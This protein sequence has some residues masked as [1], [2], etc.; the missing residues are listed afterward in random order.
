[1]SWKREQRRQR[2]R[3]ATGVGHEQPVWR[4][5]HHPHV[6]LA[7]QEHAPRDVAAHTA[8]S[9]RGFTVTLH[10]NYPAHTAETHWT[11]EARGDSCC[12][13]IW[14]KARRVVQRQHRPTRAPRRIARQDDTHEKRPIGGC[15]TGTVADAATRLD[16]PQ[17]SCE[18]PPRRGW[19]TLTPCGRVAGRARS[20]HDR[21][22]QLRRRTL[23]RSHASS[24]PATAA[25]C[26]CGQVPSLSTYSHRLER[27]RQANA[28]HDLQPVVPGRAGISPPPV[29]V[30]PMALA[31]LTSG[32]R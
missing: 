26:R 13:I 29:P 28:I 9:C 6:L 1:M 14:P 7:V 12:A 8:A 4:R 15:S 5:Q 30:L 11:G 22:R 3:G 2:A 25:S 24:P 20:L 16:T 23:R 18:A 19:D 31:D 17:L 10:E 32:A 21:S 27:H